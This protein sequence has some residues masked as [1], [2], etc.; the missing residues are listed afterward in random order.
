MSGLRPKPDMSALN[1]YDRVAA[2]DRF[3]MDGK[4]W[5]FVASFA[6]TPMGIST[7]ARGS[8]AD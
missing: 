4:E 3:L 2:T 5:R 8:E 7:K 6:L 1:F